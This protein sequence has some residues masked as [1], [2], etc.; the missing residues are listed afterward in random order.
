MVYL[1][2]A[3]EDFSHKLIVTHFKK[4]MTAEEFIEKKN[5]QFKGSV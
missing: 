2:T 5:N 1:K 3:S 4:I